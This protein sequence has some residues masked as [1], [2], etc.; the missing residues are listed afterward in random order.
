MASLLNRFWK[1]YDVQLENA[2]CELVDMRS[3][4]QSSNNNTVTPDQQKSFLRQFPGVHLSTP[5]SQ[6]QQHQMDRYLVRLSPN[7]RLLS[8]SN[9]EKT[10]LNSPVTL[11]SAEEIEIEVYRWI[12]PV[13][14]KQKGMNQVR[15]ELSLIDNDTHATV[16]I[17][18]S[19]FHD[20]KENDIK[21]L[22]VDGMDD[23]ST[24]NLRKE[25]EPETGSV[26]HTFKVLGNRIDIFVD[27]VPA[28]SG[29]GSA[30]SAYNSNRR[31]EYSLKINGRPLRL[32]YA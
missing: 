31:F 25:K 16:P 5:P 24:A 21:D 15:W 26:R 10:D 6:Q 8:P 29:H 3:K 17:S 30:V 14:K 23:I 1:K 11:S 28:A 9:E 20:Q 32:Q 4:S 2:N 18:L 27:H 19:I 7:G 12:R 13:D 22:V